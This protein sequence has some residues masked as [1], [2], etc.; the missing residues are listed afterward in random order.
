MLSKADNELLTRVGPDTPGG[1]FLRRYWH[2]IAQ[3]HDVA[4]GGEPKAIRLLGEDFVLFRLADGQLGLIDEGCPH[5]CSSMAL[6]RNEPDGLRCIFHGWKLGRDGTVLETPSE[7]RGVNLGPKVRTRHFQVRETNRLIWGYIGEGEPV[8]FP[9]F[10]FTR[11]PADQTDIAQVPGAC[12]W[13]QLL[14]GQCDSA[15]LSH[16]HSSSVTSGIGSLALNDRAPVFEIENAPWGFHIGAIRSAAAGGY[17]TRVTEFVMP[18]WNFIPPA[19]APDS[20]EYEDCPR[21]GVCQVP[22]DDV[23]T[24]V[25]YCMWRPNS[26]LT[27]GGQGTMWEVWNQ[28]WQATRHE[29][30]WAQDREKMRNGHFTGIPNLLAEDMAVAEGMKPIVDRS[31]EYLGA[32]DTAVLRFRK[33]YLDSLRAQSAGETPAVCTARTPYAIIHGHGLLHPH[34]DDWKKIYEPK[35]V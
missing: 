10:G 12:N 1:A 8:A 26:K 35:P 32:S 33:M 25:W 4:A 31:R 19:A 3:S 13:V 21:F 22:N 23:T 6:A 9:E 7:P 28:E 5:R 27:R 16:L 17:Y 30:S 24:T 14:E 18:Y 29:R 15:H 20:P 11:V 34:V 2:P